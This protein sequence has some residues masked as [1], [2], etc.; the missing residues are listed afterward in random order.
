MCLPRDCIDRVFEELLVKLGMIYIFA[1]ARGGV[2]RMLLDLVVIFVFL[3]LVCVL[4]FKSYL[5][6]IDKILF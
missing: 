6:D 1:P 5:L 2:S 4:I 3:L